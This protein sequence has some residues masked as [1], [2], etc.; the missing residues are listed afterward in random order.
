MARD[1]DRA[2]HAATA[3]SPRRSTS[4]TTGKSVTFDLNPK[5]R[6]SD[7]SP[8]T[9]DD[10]LFSF[11]LLKTKGRPNHRTY[12]G[13]VTQAEKRSMSAP[14]ASRSKTPPTANCR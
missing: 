8:V 7:R 5:A 6:F 2:V 11:E 12:F 1:L 14:C 10:V 3:C 9:A 4:R 13:K